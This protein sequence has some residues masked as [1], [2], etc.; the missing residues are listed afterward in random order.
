MRRLAQWKTGLTEDAVLYVIG[1]ANY[2][3]LGSPELQ[4]VLPQTEVSKPPAN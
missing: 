4:V 1:N 3:L 2:G